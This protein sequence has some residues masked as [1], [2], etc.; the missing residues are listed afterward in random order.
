MVVAGCAVGGARCGLEVAG[1][2]QRAWCR[3][4]KAGRL[5]SWEAG[6][7]KEQEGEKLGRLEGGKRKVRRSEGARVREKL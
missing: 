5:E 4:D 2:V 1:I 6:K 7:R 3:A